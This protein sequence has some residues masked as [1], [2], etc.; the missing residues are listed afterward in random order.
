MTYYLNKL[1][2]IG[3]IYLFNFKS[4]SLS[5]DSGYSNESG[6]QEPLVVEV[7]EMWIKL[8]QAR[9]KLLSM[10]MNNTPWVESEEVQEGLDYIVMLAGFIMSDAKRLKK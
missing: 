4:M 5:E 9:K 8:E 6:N 3:V 10:N 7:K 2:Y 1:Y